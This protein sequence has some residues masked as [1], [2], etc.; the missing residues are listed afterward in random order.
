MYST[1]SQVPAAV[2]FSAGLCLKDGVLKASEYFARYARLSRFEKL[3]ILFHI[4]SSLKEN[5]ILLWF[6]VESFPAQFTVAIGLCFQVLAGAKFV[7]CKPIC[8]GLDK[9]FLLICCLSFFCIILDIRI[10][11]LWHFWSI[12]FRLSLIL[13]GTATIQVFSTCIDTHAYTSAFNCIFF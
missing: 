9:A 6:L 7:S 11:S 8:F 1:C 4:Q 5:F 10:G 12:F 2:A 13:L 3:K